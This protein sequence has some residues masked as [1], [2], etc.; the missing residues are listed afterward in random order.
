MKSQMQNVEIFNK[1]DQFL[2]GRGFDCD[3]ARIFSFVKERERIGVFDLPRHIRG[4]VYSQLSAQI[5][6]ARVEVKL[7][8]IDE[9]FFNYDIPSIKRKDG[10]YF[11]NG[12]KRLNCANRFI[13][14]YMSGLHHNISVL[15]RID[16]IE[17]GIDNYYLSMPA[18]QLVEILAAGKYKLKWIGEA[19]AWEYLRNVGLDGIKPDVHTCRIMGANRLGYSKEAEASN[20]EV[21]SAAKEIS[22]QTGLSLSMIDAL[23]WAFC[24]ESRAS[25]CGKNP[26]C[27]ICPIATYCNQDNLA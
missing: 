21:V 8:E 26:K 22:K 5:V 18:E 10:L 14:K 2:K 12:I 9:L 4:L 27:N 15:E 19:L 7:E 16:G 3:N 6:W 13:E 23:L 11:S 1:L 20:N 17:G 25:V 24:S